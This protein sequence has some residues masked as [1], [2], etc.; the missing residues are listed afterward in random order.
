MRGITIDH[1]NW[2]SVWRQA[3][4]DFFNSKECEDIIKE[5]NIILVTW[6]ELRELNLKTSK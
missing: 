3:D 6:R 4:F 2:G 5:N 1:P